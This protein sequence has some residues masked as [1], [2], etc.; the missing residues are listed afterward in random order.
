M[1]HGVTESQPTMHSHYTLGLIPGESTVFQQCYSNLGTFDI[2]SL[3]NKVKVR[4]KLVHKPAHAQP[5]HRALK[6]IG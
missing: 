4:V 2:I 3:P 1:H 6:I 5:I